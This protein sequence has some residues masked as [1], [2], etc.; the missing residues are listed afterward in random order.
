MNR[1]M[2]AYPLF[3]K[4]PNFSLWSVTEENFAA[5]ISKVGGVRKRRFTDF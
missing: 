5:Q 1:I 2:P 4:D 3:V